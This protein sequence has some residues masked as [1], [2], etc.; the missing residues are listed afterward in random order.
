[1]LT[2]S[3]S[4]SYKLKIIL[5]NLISYIELTLNYYEWW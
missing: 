4:N 3:L 5:E 2:Y 1:M